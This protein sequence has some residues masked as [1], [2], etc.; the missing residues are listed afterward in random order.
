MTGH[1]HSF[2]SFGTVDGPGIRF[3]VFMQG[4]PLRCL[5]CHNPDTWTAGGTEYSAEEVAAR[6]LKYRNYFSGGGG[7]T[8]SGG[9]PL[10]Q[11]EFV[12]ELFTRVKGAGLNTC[13]DTSGALFDPQKPQD[14]AA[15]LAVTD[16]IL[17]DIKHIDPAEHK[18]LTGHGN[19]N[20][21]AFAKFLSDSGKRMWIR[22]V[23]VPEKT[24]RDDWLQ[25][26]RGF[27]D[28]LKTVEKV[29]VLPYHTMGVVKY[30]KLGYDYPL[31][32]VEPPTPARVENA[33]KILRAGYQPGF[34]A[35]N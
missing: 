29:E 7:I 14:L 20:I 4:C 3:V 26:L 10:L 9:E 8:V 23:L 12:T 35:E 6:A 22:H 32:G 25:A 27:L 31:R 11:K 13:L 18:K 19:E 30:E 1:I 34:S 15:L 21:L 5:Y 28:T 16:L 2:E 33:K 17:L 24:D